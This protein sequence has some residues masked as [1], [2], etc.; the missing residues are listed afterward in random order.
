MGVGIHPFISAAVQSNAET[1]N[2]G[3]ALLIG[4][5]IKS[6]FKIRFYIGLKY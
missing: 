3:L 6:S 4:N 2:N 5:Y 1:L